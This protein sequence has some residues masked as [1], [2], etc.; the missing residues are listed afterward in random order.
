MLE[1]KE[2]NQKTYKKI[3]ALWKIVLSLSSVEPRFPSVELHKHKVHFHISYS[4]LAWKKETRDK[5]FSIFAAVFLSF[6]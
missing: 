3:L 2:K 5:P 4:F 6:F 1:E